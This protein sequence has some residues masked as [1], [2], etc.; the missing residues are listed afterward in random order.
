MVVQCPSPGGFDGEASD[1]GMPGALHTGIW[2]AEGRE[3]S[4]LFE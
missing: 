2:L 3:Y 4:T 1:E